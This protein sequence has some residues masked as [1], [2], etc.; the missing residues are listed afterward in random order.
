MQIVSPTLRVHLTDVA[1][2]G[3]PDLAPQIQ[4]YIFFN[5][6]Q[7]LWCDFKIIL[8]FSF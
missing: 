7:Q 3:G 1:G 2:E 6:F 4:K 8:F 5:D